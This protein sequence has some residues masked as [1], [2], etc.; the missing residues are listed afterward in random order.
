M[1]VEQTPQ[2]V[3]LFEDT[4][5][6]TFVSLNG[7]GFRNPVEEGAQLG[8]RYICAQQVKIKTV[9]PSEENGFRVTAEYRVGTITAP[10]GEEINLGC[11]TEILCTKAPT[12]EKRGAICCGMPMILKAAKPLP[13]SD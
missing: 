7:L 9:D 5:E 2:I 10:S 3:T 4:A 11:G 13:S 12:L 1:T 8:R 6:M